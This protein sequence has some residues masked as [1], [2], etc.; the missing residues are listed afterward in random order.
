M[1]TH[2]TDRRINTLHLE[3][4]N[5]RLLATSGSDATVSIWDVRKLAPAAAGLA[6][7]NG[8]AKGAQP[9]AHLSHGKS[10]HAAYFAPDGSQVRLVAGSKCMG[11]RGA[12]V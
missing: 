6:A 9:L 7:G 3:P 12:N 11:C 1:L 2:H 8:P 5:Q 10:C 4:L